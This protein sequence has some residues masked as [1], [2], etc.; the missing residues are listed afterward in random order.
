LT[1]PIDLND[2]IAVLLAVLQAFDRAGIEAAAYGGLALA[3]YGEPRET[4]DAD[5]AVAAVTG[6]QAEAALRVAGFDVVL[7]FDRARFGGQYVSRLTLLGGT[8]G[9]L[10]TADLVEPRSPR[11]A[12]AVLAGSIT[13]SLR[14]QPL[15]VISPEDFVVMKFGQMASCSG[16]HR[17]PIHL[18]SQLS[19]YITRRSFPKRRRH[20][21]RAD[22]RAC[23]QAHS[24]DSWVIAPVVAMI[25]APP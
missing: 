20:G 11:Y 23:R 9:S 22:T 14:E 3:A 13:G 2:P 17:R 21:I 12:R 8:A 18:I 6:A 25:S 19:S 1:P 5:V 24:F 7:A 16:T 4:K 10:N 15:R